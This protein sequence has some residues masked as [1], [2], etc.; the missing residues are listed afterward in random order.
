[1]VTKNTF[2]PPP[3]ARP[4]R[5][6]LVATVG[7]E[8]GVRAFMAANPPQDGAMAERWE[9]GF[10]FRPLDVSSATV[11]FQLDCGVDAA[12]AGTALP[13]IVSTNPVGIWEYLNVSTF[14]NNRD[15]V[16]RLVTEKLLSTTSYK[17]EAE[18]WKGTVGGPLGNQYL[19]HSGTVNQLH[20]GNA[21][22]A[23]YALGILAQQAGQCE[24][25]KRLMLH[26]SIETATILEQQHVIRNVDGTWLDAMDNVVVIGAGYDGSSP[27]GVTDNVT[28]D[29]AWMYAT[30]MVDVRLGPIQTQ[31]HVSPGLNIQRV[32]AWRAVAATWGGL[33]LYGIKADLCQPYCTP[34]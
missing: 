23:P 6:G 17:L 30:G 11:P 18:F 14:N 13:G 29:T 24:Q 1:M 22:P 7:G 34:G 27:S 31:E 10:D 32:V 3:A 12:F 5:Y 16:D 26:V 4:Q 33:C 20:A 19:A 15:E 25:G 21:V 2:V 28:G 8:D 9:D